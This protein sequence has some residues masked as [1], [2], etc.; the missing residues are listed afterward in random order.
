MNRGVSIIILEYL[1]IIAPT[2]MARN[3]IMEMVKQ[4]FASVI[5]DILFSQDYGHK[6]EKFEMTFN[7]CYL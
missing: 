6:K 7:T 1:M 3:L 5:F 4:M 2:I